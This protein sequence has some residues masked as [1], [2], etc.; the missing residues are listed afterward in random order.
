M[1]KIMI[2][3]YE[4]EPEEAEKGSRKRSPHFVQYADE[5]HMIRPAP[6]IRMTKSLDPLIYS[7]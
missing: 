3:S 6:R 5:G 7:L 2:K 1:K 4:P